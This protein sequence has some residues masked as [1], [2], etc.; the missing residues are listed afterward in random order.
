M[1]TEFSDV[2]VTAFF[3]LPQ[4][5]NAETSVLFFSDK[6][7]KVY[8]WAHAIEDAIGYVYGIDHHSCDTVCV[9][10]CFTNPANIYLYFVS[11]LLNHCRKLQVAFRSLMGPKGPLHPSPLHSGDTVE[12]PLAQRTGQELN[13][14]PVRTDSA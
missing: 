4:V 12:N 6:Q 13:T 10:E 3:W 8:Q 7:E 5:S 9:H 1:K 14:L 11:L 2:T